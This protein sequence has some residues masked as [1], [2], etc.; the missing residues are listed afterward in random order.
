MATPSHPPAPPAGPG[1]PAPLTYHAHSGQA[2]RRGV[3]STILGVALIPLALLPILFP[4]CDC[5][6]LLVLLVPIGALFGSGLGLYEL[7]TG[8]HRLW[9]ACGIVLSLSAAMIITVWAVVQWYHG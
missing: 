5:L 1:A 9:S 2:H 8:E 4:A 6:R 3:R 7:I